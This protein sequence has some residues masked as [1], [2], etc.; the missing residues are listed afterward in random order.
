M[1]KRKR[2]IHKLCHTNNDNCNYSR[3]AYILLLKCLKRSG[4]Q[5]IFM[6]LARLTKEVLAVHY[7]FLIGINPIL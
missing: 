2:A 5:I 6:V 3:H 7:F 1:N 4:I